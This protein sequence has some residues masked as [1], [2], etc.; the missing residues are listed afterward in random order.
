MESHDT[1]CPVRSSEGQR[2]DE[3]A[4]LAMFPGEN[5]NPVLR[6][7]G[8]GVLLYANESSL[9]LLEHWGCETGQALPAEW[10]KLAGCALRSGEL[11][12][13]E[14][15]CAESTFTLL[16][17]P[18]VDGSYVNI[19]GQDITE[20]KG[21][22]ALLVQNEKLAT[23]GQL[24][25]GVAHEINNP[26]G[27]IYS[28]MNT[29]LEYVADIKEFAARCE[30]LCERLSSAG[31]AQCGAAKRQPA[32][33]SAAWKSC[34][35]AV[36]E[37]IEWR[38][39]KELDYTLC[40]I[41]DLVSE[42]IDGAERVKQIVQNLR[43]FSRVDEAD[44]KPSD[45]NQGLEST[46]AICWNE[47][48]YHCEVVREFGDVPEIVCYPMKLNQVFMNLIMNAAQAIEDKGTI[49]ARTFR[50]GNDICVQVSDTGC[51][52]AKEKIDKIFD[53]F[54]TTKPV[55]KGTGLGLSI[56]YNIITDHKGT[57]EVD[58]EVGKGSTF[59]V[60]LPIGGL[61]DA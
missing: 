38:K 18:L 61:E 45:I 58:S 41:E 1:A 30:T 57:I 37:M 17:K 28:N 53:P 23:I 15:E 60:R 43:T 24:A 13:G 52:I 35:T 55:G 14:A 34:S 39:E 31:A 25:A 22:E 36:S 32:N 11:Q 8:N 54:F 21:A 9:P 59:T 33:E 48:K 49:T 42:T 6:V 26:I 47:L 10:R 3:T 5:P 50:D 12:T 56:A 29:L 20:R 40:D 19:Y 51:G 27:F 44:M 4:R 7:D 16:F 46:I 2:E